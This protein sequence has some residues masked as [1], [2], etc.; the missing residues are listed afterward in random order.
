MLDLDKQV[1]K[2]ELDF[3]LEAGDNAEKNGDFVNGIQYYQKVLKI[4]ENFLIYN[5]S[6]SRI[7][8]LKKKIIKLRE[9]I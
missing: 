4:L 7:K 9:Q 5:I 3:T 8:K 1:K 2:I 6:D